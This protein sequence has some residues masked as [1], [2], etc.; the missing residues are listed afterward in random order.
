MPE[1]YSSGGD[2]G[3][4][5]L[6]VIFYGAVCPDAAV[7]DVKCSALI[8][9]SQVPCSG[10]RP[11]G[12]RWRFFLRRTSSARHRTRSSKVIVVMILFILGMVICSSYNSDYPLVLLM[13]ANRSRR[14]AL[15]GRASACACLAGS[16]QGD[17]E[18]PA[19]ASHF[20]ASAQ[21]PRNLVL[22]RGCW[23]REF[24]MFLGSLARITSRA[25]V[26]IASC[27]VVQ[28]LNQ[29]SPYIHSIVLEKSPWPG[30]VSATKFT[31]C[32]HCLCDPVPGPRIPSATTQQ[33]QIC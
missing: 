32:S 24:S 8:L 20:L 14:T 22:R 9:P 29:G 4:Q 6:P 15:L 1:G 31:G 10:A 7:V 16:K 33:S 3:S 2:Q 23:C 12:Q 19:P 13:S 5:G 27:Q 30:D 26:T 18:V 17:L 25:P 11:D 28:I 21:C